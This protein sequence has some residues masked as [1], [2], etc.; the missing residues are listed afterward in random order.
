MSSSGSP[1]AVQVTLI[2]S[3]P[4]TDSGETSRLT[5]G[6]SLGTVR[7]TIALLSALS[8]ITEQLRISTFHVE[9]LIF[10]GDLRGSPG[11]GL[12]VEDPLMLFAWILQHKSLGGVIGHQRVIGCDLLWGDFPVQ[13]HLGLGVGHT[14]GDHSRLVWPQVDDLKVDGGGDEQVVVVC[15]EGQKGVCFCY[16]WGLFQGLTPNCELPEK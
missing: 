12:A 8:I 2:L 7:E 1:R 16:C 10:G 14:T 13:G 5:Y 9:Q 3:P 15:H 4:L 6:G 11:L